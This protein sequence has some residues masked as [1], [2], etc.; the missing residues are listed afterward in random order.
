MN[1]AVAFFGTDGGTS[2]SSFGFDRALGGIGSNLGNALFHYSM[3]N[4]I[5]APKFRVWPGFDVAKIRANA[6][7]LVIPAANQVN[8]EW[9]LGKWAELV[10]N[11]DLP[12]VCLGLGAQSHLDSGA[13]LP[14]KPGTRRFLSVLAERCQTI[15]VRGP[16]TQE[17]LARLGIQN[18]MVTGC[19]SQM[20]NQRITGAQI[21]EKLEHAATTENIRAAHV[22]GTLAPDTRETERRLGQM[23][24]NT[25]HD[26]I[27]QTEARLLSTVLSR[28]VAEENANFLAWVGKVFHPEMSEQTFAEYFLRHAFMYSDARTW[29]DSMTRYD[30]VFGMR[31][32]G[33]VA[34]IQGETAG[35]CVAFDSRTLE[36][37]ET[38]GY[39]YIRSDA[40]H[41][42]ITLREI[43]ENAVFSA[44]TFDERKARHCHLMRK[45]L[46]DA[47]C[48]L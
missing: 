35:I 28:K 12:V 8:P 6:K 33:A 13:D 1:N 40:I 9:D 25:D 3:W 36:L 43:C 47:G 31:I 21:Q 16:F 15:G 37:A 11:C 48:I 29:I 30:L 4:Q 23:I 38:M 42:G 20:I 14:L 46:N 5:T 18:T 44:A 39:P 41:D 7:V 45:A 2:F 10:E 22:L 26:L 32:H 17:V 27:L 24:R 34:A 19:P